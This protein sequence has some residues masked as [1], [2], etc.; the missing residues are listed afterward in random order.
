M[1]RIIDVMCYCCCLQVWLTLADAYD[2]C[3]HV[4][5]LLFAGVADVG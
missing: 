2:I 1:P 4:L 3:C 5:L